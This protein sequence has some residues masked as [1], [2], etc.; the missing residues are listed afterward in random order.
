[1][2]DMRKRVCCRTIKNRLSIK[3]Q[4]PRPHR[5]VIIGLIPRPSCPGC[6]FPDGTKKPLLDRPSQPLRTPWDSPH[7]R[8]GRIRGNQALKLLNRENRRLLQKISRLGPGKGLESLGFME[9]NG[10]TEGDKVGLLAR[11]QKLIVTVVSPDALR[12][13]TAEFLCSMARKGSAT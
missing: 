7:G 10:I 4:T 9:G 5:A 12:F 1:M 2:D 11:M 6:D 3:H 8:A 13:E